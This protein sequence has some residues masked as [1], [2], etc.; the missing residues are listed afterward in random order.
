M[1]F[2]IS[3]H[4]TS[5]DEID[6]VLADESWIFI[7]EPKLVFFGRRQI[8]YGTTEASPLTFLTMPN[9]SLETRCSTIG[10]PTDNIE[11]SP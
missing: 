7:C 10:F 2:G 1:D 3:L 11:V 9:D 4:R 6:A 8:A 5:E